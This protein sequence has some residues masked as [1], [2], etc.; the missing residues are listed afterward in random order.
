VN[1]FIGN[2]A[3][4]ITEDELREV[5]LKFGEVKHV[6]VMNDAY[7]GSG[8]TTGYGYV[9]MASKSEGTNAISS[10]DGKKL[11]SLEVQVIEA[12]P[13]TDRQKGF[14]RK[15]RSTYGVSRIRKRH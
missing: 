8:K 1:I 4:N 9:K 7:I 6:V 3:L 11:R 10:L 12:L 5:F 13:L 14:P 2:L 15:T